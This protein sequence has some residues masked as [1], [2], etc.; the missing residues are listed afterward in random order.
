MSLCNVIQTIAHNTQRKEDLQDVFIIIAQ[1]TTPL[2]TNSL[3]F[4]SLLPEETKQAKV[5]EKP[6][7]MF[8]MQEQKIGIYG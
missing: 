8:K 2:V 6:S 5:W 4:Y 1:C 7:T 3:L